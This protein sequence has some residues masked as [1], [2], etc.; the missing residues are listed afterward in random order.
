MNLPVG[1]KTV[2]FYDCKGITGTAD[3]FRMSDVLV[4]LIRFEA[5][6][7]RFLIPHF[8]L[9]PR[10]AFPPEGDVGKIVLPEGMKSVDFYD[11]SGLTG[12]A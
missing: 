12:T 10:F 8:I 4:Y 3:I 1:M 7:N 2:C 6:R 9:F 11:C 5:S